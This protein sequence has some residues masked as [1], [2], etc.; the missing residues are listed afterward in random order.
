M[1]N[2]IIKANVKYIA[3]IMLLIDPRR[4]DK[5]GNENI[6]DNSLY[7][8]LLALNKLRAKVV[9][10]SNHCRPRFFVSNNFRRVSIKKNVL[11][12]RI[13]LS[14]LNIFTIM[15]ALTMRAFAR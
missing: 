14:S 9:S 4:Q 15:F 2:V 1:E 13:L 3:Y 5:E 10:F 6:F 12:G 8:F 7:A 11:A